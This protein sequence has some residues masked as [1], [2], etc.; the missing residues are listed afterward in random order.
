MECL[1]VKERYGKSYKLFKTRCCAGMPEG[2]FGVF[3]DENTHTIVTRAS[4]QGKKMPKDLSGL[5]C[6]KTMAKA[7]SSKGHKS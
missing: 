2:M 4:D 5:F 1:G 7:V 3:V 6:V